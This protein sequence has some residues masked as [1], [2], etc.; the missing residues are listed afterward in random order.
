MVFP[1]GWLNYK[2]ITVQNA[3][4]AGDLTD[5]PAVYS[6]TDTDLTKAR[7]DGFDFVVT[8]SDGTTVVPYERV[9]WN[10]ST[11]EI[12]L[13]IKTDPLGAS[14]VTYRLYYNSL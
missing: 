4:V 1:D 11:G 7:A 9:L 3:E 13:W 5:F 6:E 12:I 10:D 2:E 8:E 14:N